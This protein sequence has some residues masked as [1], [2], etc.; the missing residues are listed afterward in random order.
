MKLLSGFAIAVLASATFAQ[1]NLVKNGDFSL[2]DA[3]GMPLLWKLDSKTFHNVK[4]A[5][6]VYNGV[7]VFQKA[8]ECTPGG[9]TGYSRPYPLVTLEQQVALPAGVPIEFSMD[10]AYSKNYAGTNSD[11]GQIEVLLGTQSLG[12]LPAARKSITNIT[13]EVDHYNSRFTLTTG[14][15]VTL[16]IT[17]QRYYNA[18]GVFCHLDNVYCGIQPGAAFG[19]VGD[20]KI[21]QSFDY[22]LIGEPNS[23]CV[24]LF[25]AGP[26]PTPGGL[27]IPGFG[28]TLQLELPSLLVFWVEPLPASGEVIKTAGSFPN[29]PA[30]A[31]VPFWW[32]SLQVVPSPASFTLGVGRPFAWF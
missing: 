1:A 31:G 15:L 7:T 9:A 11:R 10:V 17:V 3:S 14:G 22:R 19:F 21:G 5:D 26:W 6:H 18:T 12:L 24:V 8:L 29:I 25:A 13:T 30:L 16:K 23:T 20:R 27:Q 28:G 2:L 32:Q 4:V